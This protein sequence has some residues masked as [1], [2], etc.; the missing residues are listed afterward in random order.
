[1][2]ERMRQL[3]TAPRNPGML[4][5]PNLQ[6]SVLGQRLPR[7]LDL[8]LAAEHQP[9]E[10]QSLGLGPAFRQP[11]SDEHLIRAFLRH[12]PPYRSK[13]RVSKKEGLVRT[14]ITKAQRISAAA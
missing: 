2:L 3:D 4:L 10:D 7:F 14:K 11:S 5:A 12:H 6:R 9:G 1:M 8:A 13:L